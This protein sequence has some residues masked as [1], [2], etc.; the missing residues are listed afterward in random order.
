MAEDAAAQN[1]ADNKS[2]TVYHA[3]KERIV[4]GVYSPGYRLVLDQLAR[5]LSVSPVPV[6]EAVRRLEAEGYVVFQRNVGARVASIDEGAYEHAMEALAI[7]EGAATALS[8]PELTGD[9]VDRARK[10]NE[11]M[12]TSLLEF[13]PVRFTE[14]NH[15]FHEM[16]CARCPNPHL[17][18][19]IE[20]EWARLGMIRRS[21]FAFVPGRA[22]DSIDEHAE[23]LEL[24]AAGGPLEEVERCA[25]AH[26]LATLT[27]FKHR[28]D[29][30]A[31][32][33][34]QDGADDTREDDR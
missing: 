16:L 34:G 20:R 4:D 33:A 22:Q 32:H 6:R 12:R 15:E 21:T 14:L 17:R 7:L 31:S 8:V 29:E 23:L 19:L 27:S 10:V 13:D 5:E 28:R 1:A 24:I 2:E 3:V 9:D 30:T 26:K 18:T 11:R 25:R